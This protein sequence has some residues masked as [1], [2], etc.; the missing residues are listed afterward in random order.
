MTTTLCLAPLKVALVKPRYHAS[1]D[2]MKFWVCSAPVD[3][4][5]LLHLTRLRW[6]IE[7]VFRYL[8]QHLRLETCIIRTP[9]ILTT[10]WN[11]LWYT[12]NAVATHQ[13]FGTNWASA[14]LLWRTRSNP[15]AT[16]HSALGVA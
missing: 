8:K 4:P 14:K 15:H 7:V 12:Y 5:T 13:D 3:V 9:E 16:I 6:R 11:L 2:D 10:W 1:L